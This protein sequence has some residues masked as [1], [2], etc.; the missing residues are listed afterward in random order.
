MRHEA[1]ALCT[2]PSELLVCTTC[3]PAGAARDEP[4]A[5]E[6]FL[7]QVLAVQPGPAPL[8]AGATA[9]HDSVVV[10]GIACLGVCSRSCA[11]ALQAE[12][13]MTY[14]FGDL[15]PDAESAAQLLVCAQQHANAS[16]GLLAWA[17]RPERL[18][19]GL[20]ARLPPLQAQPPESTDAPSEGMPS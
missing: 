14:V 15:A 11:I 4:A 20:V 17:T 19:R 13:K 8:A 12:G 5:G 1:H 2:T 3:R 10:R 18:R 9:T 7:A 16:D 6:Q